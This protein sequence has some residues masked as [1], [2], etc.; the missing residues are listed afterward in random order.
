MSVSVALSRSS[1]RIESI[2]LDRTKTEGEV[3]LSVSVSG[4]E[5]VKW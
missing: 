3:V 2:H 5:Q 4:F 1:G